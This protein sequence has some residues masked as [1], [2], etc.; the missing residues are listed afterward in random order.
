MSGLIIAVRLWMPLNRAPAARKTRRAADRYSGNR[1][2][3]PQG[4]PKRGRISAELGVLL[5]AGV[6][7]GHR[8][9]DRGVEEGGHLQRTGLA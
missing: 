2:A 7:G 5:A 8:Q 6:A 1:D 3:D 9:T 4:E